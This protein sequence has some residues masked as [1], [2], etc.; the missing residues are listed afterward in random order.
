MMFHNFTLA[1]AVCANEVHPLRPQSNSLQVDD[2]MGPF[3]GVEVQALGVPCLKGGL[4]QVGGGVPLFTESGIYSASA[5]GGAHKQLMKLGLLHRRIAGSQLVHEDVPQADNRIDLDPEI[6]DYHGVPAGPHHLQ[7]TPA[8][9]GRRGAARRPDGGLAR[10]RRRSD[11][12]R[13]HSLSDPQPGRA[14]PL[15]WPERHGWDEAEEIRVRA[16]GRMHEV[17]NVYIADASTL[18]TFPGHNPTN[19]IMANALRIARGIGEAPS[20]G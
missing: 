10:A 15:T 17:D 12:L 9:D 13:D 4:V 14:R 1:A 5:R 2:L 19:T 6:K 16:S 18:P 7:P 20:R 8:R 11:R 3:K